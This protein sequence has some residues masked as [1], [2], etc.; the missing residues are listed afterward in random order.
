MSPAVCQS[1]SSRMPSRRIG[2]AVRPSV[3]AGRPRSGGAAGS[4]AAIPATRT[5][6]RRDAL[7]HFARRDGDQARFPVPVARRERQDCGR[8]DQETMR[9]V[10]AFRRVPADDAVRLR[11]DRDELARGLHVREDQMRSGIILGVADLSSEIDAPDALVGLP[12]DNGLF[13]T[14]FIRD[15]DLANLRRVRQAVWKLA[16]GNP[17]QEL[18]GSG[19]DDRDFMVSWDTDEDLLE[20]RHDQNSRGAREPWEMSDNLSGFGIQDHQLPVTHVGEIE[21]LGLRVEGLIIEAAWLSREPQIDHL[22]QTGLTRFRPWGG[23]ERRTPEG[24]GDKQDGCGC[25]LF[26]CHWRPP[27]RL[28]SRSP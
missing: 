27:P 25:K 26:P 13:P 12:I 20:L 24:R 17:G 16:V 22:G 11:I 9:A 15:E 2:P 10:A 28:R 23:R 7:L 18:Q 8:I 3:T 19:I 1:G 6:A 5:V 21:P 14:L 4:D